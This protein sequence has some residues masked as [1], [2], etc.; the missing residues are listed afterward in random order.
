MKRLLQP[1]LEAVADN[2]R[3]F[4]LIQ[5]LAAAVVAAYYLVP[6]L[7]DAFSAV[8]RFRAATGI[9]FAVGA[10]VVA[11]VIL[12]EIAKVVTGQ[13]DQLISG[14]DAAWLTAF[15]ASIGAY[16]YLL[17][18]LLG[19]IA[20]SGT[21]LQTVAS[22]VAL[23][24][25]V[26]SPTMSIPYSTMFM[27]FRDE[28]YNA[29]KTREML[30]TGEFIRRYPTLLV[31]AWAFWIPVL[32]AVYAMPSS[33]QVPLFVVVQAAWCLVLVH[34]TSTRRRQQK[35]P[36]MQPASCEKTSS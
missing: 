23:D 8:E 11:S 3:A 10:T 21:D 2:W 25:F 33:L 29:A 16:V 7:G 26:S 30:R 19:Q 22:K 24:M 1:G 4:V 13:K 27:L 18:E 5:A 17:Y 36:S 31:N 20:G 28:G 15:F 35:N 9:W 32:F 6:A 12:P 14:R 34:I